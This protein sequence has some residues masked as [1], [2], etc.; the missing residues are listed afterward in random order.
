MT[1]HNDNVVILC[2]PP[3]DPGSGGYGG[4]QGGYVRNVT[5]LLE[6]FSAGNVRL[7]LSPY[8]VRRYHPCWRLLLPFRIIADILVF[9]KNIRRG[10]AVHLMMTYRLAI[11]REFAIGVLARASGRPLILDIRGGSFLNW[12]PVASA[13]PRALARWL[14]RHAEVILGQGMAVV[15][16]LR[17]LYGE[18]VHY[19]PNFIGAR[20]IPAQPALKCSQPHLNVLFVGYCYAGKGVFEL[21]EGCIMAAQAGAKV[22]LSLVGSESPDFAQYLNSVE[23][24]PGFVLKRFGTLPHEGVL[25]HFAS[26][27]VFCFPS[28]HEGE[29]HPNVITEAMAY[30]LII[31]TTRQGFV[32]ELLDERTAYFIEKGQPGAISGALLYIDTHRD[33]ACA[34][35]QGAHRVL[36]ERFVDNIVL[37]ELRGHYRRAMLRRDGR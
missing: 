21:V 6:Y 3:Q 12:L 34:K 22:H 9:L 28:R 30:G 16:P 19:F 1:R 14:L 31:V 25:Q 10:Q 17:Q 18:K 20:H 33:E 36:R 4:G 23:P 5:A 27:D 2:G 29:G 37:E 24:H 11:Y 7:T 13:L 15:L 32:A 35:A 8:S 26:N